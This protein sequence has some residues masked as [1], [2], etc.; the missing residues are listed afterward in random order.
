R[1][2]NA[3]MHGLETVTDVGQSSPDDYAHGVIQVRSA[4]L[5]FD[6]YSDYPFF[7]CG[8]FSHRFSSLFAGHHRRRL[9]AQ[10]KP[11][12]KA[13]EQTSIP[14]LSFPS[15]RASCIPRGIVAAVVFPKRSIVLNTFSAGIPSC[16][17]TISLIRILAW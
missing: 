11:L 9:D 16:F 7:L 1:V 3:A 4:H 8:R 6:L 5:V 2:K 15:L 12:P 13:A 17:A 14:G 10:V